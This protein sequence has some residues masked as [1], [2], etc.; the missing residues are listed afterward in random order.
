MFLINKLRWKRLKK[1]FDQ[2]DK[3]FWA[4]EDNQKYYGKFHLEFTGG[5]PKG[6]ILD[7]GCD[8]FIEK[9]KRI[10]ISNFINSNVSYIDVD[11]SIGKH[12]DSYVFIQAE[13]EMFLVK[14]NL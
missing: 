9:M 11:P 8:S 10:G 6:K 3:E 2:K 4:S 7:I 5:I 12:D 1:Q 14:M 13:G